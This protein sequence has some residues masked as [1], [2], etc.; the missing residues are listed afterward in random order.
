MIASRAFRRSFATTTRLLQKPS[1]KPPNPPPN[2]PPPP[3]NDHEPP[4]NNK[5]AD[6]E[7][8]KGSEELLKKIKSCF[9]PSSEDFVFAFANPKLAQEK[10]RKSFLLFSAATLLA[11]LIPD[12]W[13]MT[14]KQPEQEETNSMVEMVISLRSNCPRMSLLIL[15]G[16]VQ[17]AFVERDRLTAETRTPKS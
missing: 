10:R 14:G 4:K 12:P 15:P 2:H 11:L 7:V 17:T 9:T 8:P 3:R 6:D 13:G 1:N 16:Q 5:S